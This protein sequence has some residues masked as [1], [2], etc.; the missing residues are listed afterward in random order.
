MS[1][2]DSITVEVIR[3]RLLS[4]AREMANN[5]MR[6]AYNTIVYEIRDFGL[7]IYDRDGNLVAEAP[8]LTIF[9]RANDFA[10]QGVIDFVGYENLDPGDAIL[11]NYPYW[12]SAHT[13]DVAC[14]T[15]IF[16]DGELVGF[17]AVRIHWLD[18]SQKDAGYCLDTTDMYEEGIFLPCSKVYRRGELNEDVVNIIKF[19]SRLPERVLG[20]MHAQISACRVGERRTLEIIDRYGRDTYDQAI[21]NILEHGERLAL[22]RLA[23]LPVGTWSAEDYVDDD[24]IE[25]RLVKLKATVSISPEKF[26]VD[27]TGSD[28]A[29]KGPI[30]MPYGLTVGISSLIFKAITT[31]ETTANG[32][33]FAPLEVIAP[34]G[35]VMHA[36]PPAPTFTLWTGLLAGEVIL[37][38]L[39]QAD[40]ELVPACSGG[41]VCSMM[42]LGV[43]P[44]SG[45]PWLEATNEGVGFGGHAG[46][47][48]E[49]GIMHLTEP[50]CRNNPVEALETKAPLL[51][52]HYGLRPDSGG[53]GQHRG[54]LGISRAYR[55][56]ADSTAIMLVKKTKTRPWSIDRGMEGE[57]CH[58]VL[59]PGTDREQVTSGFYRSVEAGDVLVNNSG[60]GGGWGDPLDRDP[61]RV[62]ED[63]RYGYVTAD[64]ARSEYGVAIDAGTLTVDRDE[65]EAL[66]RAARADGGPRRTPTAADSIVEG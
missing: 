29:T 63:V 37:K 49:N 1:E 4:A 55:F 45:R 40:P 11:V 59:D 9:T 25:N 54:G 20:D 26:E 21:V 41:D 27:W 43:N 38:A 13:L 47:D 52:E 5:L 64:R 48:G 2:V 12:S 50:G 10:L 60:G 56:L 8:G 57:N 6:T 22:A 23:E 39:A 36:V 31:P 24:G 44:G 15:P 61:E 14:C 19:N 16:H 62:R 7:G 53:P 66:R 34:A 3:H 42:G 18:L 65:T 17:T 33:N 51:I 32:G 28:D 46:G 35:S 30:N 58:V